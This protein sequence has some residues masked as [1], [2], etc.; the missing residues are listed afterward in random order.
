MLPRSRSAQ[1]APKQPGEASQRH[2]TPCPI[3]THSV[4]DG[5]ERYR[6]ALFGSAAFVSAFAFSNAIIFLLIDALPGLA[7]GTAYLIGACVV[8]GTAI[9][10]VLT[11]GVSGRCLFG[12]CPLCGTPSPTIQE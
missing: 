3:D 11:L 5:I 2:I 6:T 4:D 9:I 12:K 8:T 10:F 1:Q 7:Y